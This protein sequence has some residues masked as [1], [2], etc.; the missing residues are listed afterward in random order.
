M[1]PPNGTKGR[2]ETFVRG[3]GDW[4]DL[5]LEG[6]TGC[7]DEEFLI[8]EKVVVPGAGRQMVLRELRK[9]G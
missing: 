4:V 9:E 7:I 2:E 5:T 3:V 6:V 8:S 1:T